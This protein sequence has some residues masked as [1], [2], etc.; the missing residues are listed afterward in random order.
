M[1]KAAPPFSPT[2]QGKRYILPKPMAEPAA[3]A[4][5]PSFEPKVSLLSFIYKNLYFPI[6]L[7]ANLRIIL[8]LL[9]LIPG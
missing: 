3:A 1:I 4:I 2:I 9:Y 6:S 7:H 8:R 5:M